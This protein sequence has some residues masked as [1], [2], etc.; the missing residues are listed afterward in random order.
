MI[1]KLPHFIRANLFT[2]AR[3]IHRN[4]HMPFLQVTQELFGR[5]FDI[6]EPFTEGIVKDF[7]AVS[8]NFKHISHDI[9]ATLKFI[10][11][12]GVIVSSETIENE[13]FLNEAIADQ[14]NVENWFDFAV[15]FFVKGFLANVQVQA[16]E[17][18]WNEFNFTKCE[19]IIFDAT[20]DFVKVQN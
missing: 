13:V 11:I 17:S 14:Q 18:T 12:N 2:D 20:E 3:V 6:N 7:D 5:K 8:F 4:H 16:I 9:N 15:L 19:K 1:Y 10:E